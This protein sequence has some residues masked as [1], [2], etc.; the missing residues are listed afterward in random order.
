MWFCEG[1][2][3]CLEEACF[4]YVKGLSSQAERSETER[5]IALS[6]FPLSRKKRKKQIRQFKLTGILNVYTTYFKMEPKNYLNVV[7]NEVNI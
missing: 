6:L 5:L 2:K 3:A 4:S 7:T 1:L